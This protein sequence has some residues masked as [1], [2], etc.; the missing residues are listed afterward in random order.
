MNKDRFDQIAQK[1]DGPSRIHLAETIAAEVN[2][3]FQ[4]TSYQSLLDYGGG[5]GLVTLNIDHHFDE[6]TMMDAAPQMIEVF[7]SKISELGKTHIHAHVGDILSEDTHI[8]TTYDVIFLSLVLLHSGDYT[9][10]LTAL[11]AKLNSGG[12]LVLVDFDKNESIYHPKVYNGFEQ[13]DIQ[14]LFTELGLTHIQS[15]TFYEGKNIFMNKD[16]SLFIATGR[17]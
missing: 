12:L 2:K 8:N 11:R 7:E 3:V 13:S 10:L 5:T 1:Y 4:N 9:A 14:Q 15:H 17:S 6:V 16:A